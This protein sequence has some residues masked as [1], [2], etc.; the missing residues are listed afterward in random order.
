MSDLS[1]L[2]KQK[3]VLREADRINPEEIGQL[4]AGSK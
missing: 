1:G 2:P 3:L 4:W